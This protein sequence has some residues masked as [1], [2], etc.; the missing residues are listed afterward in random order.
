MKNKNDEL[1]TLPQR[2]KY[3]RK[4][5]KYTLDKLATII[6]SSKSYLWE[7]ESGKAKN[8]SCTF[9]MKLANALKTDL[10]YLINGKPFEIEE[11]FLARYRSLSAKGKKILDEIMNILQSNHIF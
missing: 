5:H 3:L 7:I 2:L 6:G 10:V 4:T 8:I 9:L 11:V 1:E